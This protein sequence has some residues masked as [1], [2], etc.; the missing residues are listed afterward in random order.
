MRRQ[1]SRQAK[2]A[3]GRTL[4]KRFMA[5]APCTEAVPA[6]PLHVGKVSCHRTRLNALDASV[7][8]IIGGGDSHH[9]RTGLS[10][11]RPRLWQP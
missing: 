2:A 6:R 8:I 3:V 5:S 1:D 10:L 4:L 11:N 9:G 7:L